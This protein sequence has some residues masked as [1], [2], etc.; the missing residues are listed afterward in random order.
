MI[1][2][3]RQTFFTD[4]RTFISSSFYSYPLPAL[5]RQLQ[6]PRQSR[7]LLAES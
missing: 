7:A 4:A 6:L 2:Q 1:L 5:S 3:L